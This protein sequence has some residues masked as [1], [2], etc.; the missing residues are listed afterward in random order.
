MVFSTLFAVF[1]LKIVDSYQIN[2]E[3]TTC[4]QMATIVGLSSKMINVICF[5]YMV[6]AGEITPTFEDG[7]HTSFASLYG[8]MI[9]TPFLGDKF[10]EICPL[11]IIVCSMAYAYLGIFNYKSKA[12]DSLVLFNMKRENEA[13]NEGKKLSKIDHKRI[14]K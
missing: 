1:N 7:V 14:E 4:F 13:N 5:N 11:L 9:K 10:N 6:I 12:V 8:A 3:R 2:P